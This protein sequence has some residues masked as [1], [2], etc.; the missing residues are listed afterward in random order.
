MTVPYDISFAPCHVELSGIS[1]D[2]T[3]AI[4]DDDNPVLVAT[5]PLGT[6][7]VPLDSTKLYALVQASFDCVTD[8]GAHSFQRKAGFKV[9]RARGNSTLASI[10]ITGPSTALNDDT[11]L[12]WD[13]ASDSTYFQILTAI[14]GSGDME[15]SLKG[16]SGG[17]TALTFRNLVVTYRILGSK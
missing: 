10:S 6:G 16:L 7:P 14:N 15:I 1:A 4:P 8:N 3:I 2:G 11:G 13:T 17:G 5:V 12:Y 9:T